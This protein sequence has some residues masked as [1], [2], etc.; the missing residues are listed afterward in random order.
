V[1]HATTSTGE[2]RDVRR[3]TAI[4]LGGAMAGAVLAG[5][6]GTMATLTDVAHGSATVGAGELSLVVESSASSLP[7]TPSASGPATVDVQRTGSGTVELWLSAIDGQGA[8]ACSS[9]P[10][11]TV[12]VGR[13]ADHTEAR[14]EL[15]D[16]VKAPSRIA[17]LADGVQ[18]TQLTVRI[19]AVNAPGNG[20]VSKTWNGDLRFLLMQPGG[21]FSDQQGVPAYVSTPGNGNGNK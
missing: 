17:V 11:A 20:Q 3:R 5:G 2:E 12:F 18:S 9:L 10:N 14:A 8:D 13:A 19:T 1:D 4:A 15:C 7:L 21:G 6:G 16:L